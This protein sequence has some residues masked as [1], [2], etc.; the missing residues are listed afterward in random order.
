VETEEKEVEKKKP[1]ES[2]RINVHVPV[3]DSAATAAPASSGGTP[4]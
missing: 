2:E 4:G 3:E 1:L